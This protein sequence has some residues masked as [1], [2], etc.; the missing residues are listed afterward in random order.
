MSVSYSK[1]SIVKVKFRD[2][3]GREAPIKIISTLL[4]KNLGLVPEISHCQ[5]F[6][7]SGPNYIKL[8]GAYNALFHLFGSIPVL[9]RVNV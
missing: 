3:I 4:V 8:V 7:T 1:I 2:I 5:T 9:H 6:D